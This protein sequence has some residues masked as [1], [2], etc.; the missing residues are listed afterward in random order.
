MKISFLI[1]I[2]LLVGCKKSGIQD[3]EILEVKFLPNN[4]TG[5]GSVN[6]DTI[7]NKVV[8][9]N[10]S[11]EKFI[12]FNIPSG[13]KMLK[14]QTTEYLGEKNSADLFV[15]HGKYPELTGIYPY[16]YVADCAST[17]ENREKDSCVFMNP[18]S[19]TWHVM[20]YGYNTFFTSRLIVIAKR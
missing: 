1:L 15:R 19:G 2:V 10:F 4:N 14:I 13:I 11:E 17:S 6:Q 3:F 7:I 18:Q 20:L 8:N 16:R 12:S 9:G 5:T